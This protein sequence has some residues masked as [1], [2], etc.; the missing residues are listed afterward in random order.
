MTPSEY[1]AW[2]AY[3]NKYGVLTI[4]RR[5]EHI[6][7]MF[8]HYLLKGTVPIEDLLFFSS[9]VKELSLDEAVETWV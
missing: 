3:R 8:F 2:E 5:L 4:Q 9:E 1:L 7:A 6:T